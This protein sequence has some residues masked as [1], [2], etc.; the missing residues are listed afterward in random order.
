MNA[1]TLVALFF[2][3][4]SVSSQANQYEVSGVTGELSNLNGIYSQFSTLNGKP[5]YTKND[6][7]FMPLAYLYFHS[8]DSESGEWR[9]ARSLTEI[10]LA[11]NQSQ[12][13]IPPETGWI[14]FLPALNNF[15]L[16]RHVPRITFSRTIW[17]ESASND[18]TFPQISRVTHNNALGYKFNGSVG[19]DFI[20][21][22]RVTVTNL[23][24]GLTAKVIYQSETELEVYF[25]GNAVFSARANSV[26]DVTFVFNDSAF[27][28]PLG[29]V[30]DETLGAVRSDIT[31]QFRDEINVGDE[32]DYGTIAAAVSAA[33]DFDIIR[34]AAGIYTEKDIVISK[35][36]SIIGAGAG[37]TIVQAAETPGTAGITA[38]GGGIPLAPT[39]RVFRVFFN[40]TD[41]LFSDLTIRH[42]HLRGQG[43]NGA[44]IL[45]NSFF[46]LRNCHITLNKAEGTSS[47]FGAGVYA[48]NGLRLENCL[49]DEN[50]LNL[51][52]AVTSG[53]AGLYVGGSSTI[54][55]STFTANHL[56]SQNSGSADMRGGALLSQTSA[57]VRIINSTIVG[58]SSVGEGGGI[59]FNQSNSAANYE[60]INSV[61]TDNESILAIDGQDVYVN[62]GDGTVYVRHSIIDL[63]DSSGSAPFVLENTMNVPPLLDVLDNYG[64]NTN[65]F[66][67]LSGSPAIGAGVITNGVPDLDQRGFS[68]SGNPD[69]GAFQYDGTLPVYVTYFANGGSGSVPELGHSLSSGKAFTV[70]NGDGLALQDLNFDGWNSSP[71]GSGVKYVPGQIVIADIADINLYAQWLPDVLHYT[72]TYVAGTGGFIDGDAS[73]TVIEGD[74]GSAVTAIADTGYSFVDWSDGVTSATRQDMDVFSNLSV[75]ANFALSE[76]TVTFLVN[77]VQFDQQ[78][79]QHGSGAVDPGVPTV[80]GYDFIDWDVD[81]SDVTSDLTVNAILLIKTYPVNFYDHENNLI[82]TVYVEHGSSAPAPIAPA[83]DGYTFTG[84]SVDLASVTSSL[85]AIAQYDINTFSVRFLDWDAS[86][87]STETVNWNEAATA[88]ADPT[89]DGHTFTSWDV[90]FA[91]VTSDL[92]VTAQYDINT[93]TVRFLDW[94]GSVLTTQA[95]NWNEAATAPAVPERDGHTFTGWDVGFTTITSDLDVTAQYDIN[96]FT[97][98]FLDWDG[99]V[100]STQTVNW[101]TEA[102]AP[103][104]PERDGHT[105]NGWDVSFT[106]V[107]SD[108]DVTAQY[109]INTFTVRFLDWDDSVL[110]TETVN[111]N[112]GA[113]APVDPERE[114]Y[115]FTGW[116]AAF[117]VITVNLD[118]TAKYEIN[119]YTVTVNVIGPGLPIPSLFMVAHGEQIEFLVE[120]Q[121]QAQLVSALGC[122]GAVDDDNMY[123]TA[124]IVNDCEI[125]LEFEATPRELKRRR[126]LLLII[127]AI[128][129]TENQL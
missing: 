9:F 88:P 81:F 112:E 14:S 54:V 45:A 22:G 28:G 23:P 126:S 109:D 61:I 129:R 120:P 107:T 20:D 85:D 18:G 66:Q 43:L 32:G 118:V 80:T 128:R 26:D 30:P 100:L 34:V 48:E 51:S 106:T 124:G 8:P 2:V 59:V 86:V 50:E 36:L 63:V 3:F 114:G 110:T 24:D 91:A 121:P 116:S 78:T 39:G 94:D 6:I 119:Y 53:G 125:I 70:S 103:A 92:D 72:L 83:R 69:I 87:L 15:Q 11:T 10:P 29:T 16:T 113:T 79:V 35:N 52:T 95:V 62:A 74:S 42:G 55:N 98:R 102:T 93:F 122:D 97:V 89:R 71:D 67:L 65:G 101:N 90:G 27:T 123:R 105:F 17:I 60:I 104:V 33:Q 64:G 57:S 96:T 40:L 12:S 38:P 77:G 111:W 117:D 4:F 25:E 127:E 75:T 44:G 76:Y 31:L 82:V 68:R 1:R 108:L 37:Q 58:N 19:E 73:Q 21:T 99:S 84:W 7:Y 41:V 47:S 49:I 115:T 46:T 5:V 56:T 13:E